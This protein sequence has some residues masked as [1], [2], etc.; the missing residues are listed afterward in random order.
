MFN[1]IFDK[2]LLGFLIAA[3]CVPALAAEE[4]DGRTVI[5][6]MDKRMAFTECRMLIRIVDVKAD[7]KSRRMEAMVAYVKD[8]G[9]RLDFEE[10]ARDRGKRVL[11]IG[12]SMWMSSPS[13]SKPVRL[14]GKD[15]FM[16]TSFT[17]D[18]V[19]N[20]DKADDYDAVISSGNETGWTVVMSAKTAS[21]PYAR[22]EARIG[23]DFLPVAMTYYARSG[24]ESKK[25]AFSEVKSFG[26]KRRP[27]VMTIT[28]LMKP[29][30]TSS[31]IFMEI[32]E[33]P[34]DRSRLTPSSLGN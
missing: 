15:A 25:V 28:D 30:D 11:M 20:L 17:N 10:P 27:S 2:K 33:E 23:K 18:D 29:G 1:R 21:L 16:G 8:V 7:G 5:A 12:S 3:F 34:V 26:G 6:E 19:M 14:S 32:S 22:I 13:V 24:R 4:L 9:T 31:V